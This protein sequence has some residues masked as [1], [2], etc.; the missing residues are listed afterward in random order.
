MTPH[1]RSLG[2]SHALAVVGAIVL[3]VACV[4]PWW[5]AGGGEGIPAA[6][7][8][9][10]E[11][12]G[13]LVFLVAIATLALVALPYAAGDR[14]VALDR[15]LSYAILS[16]VGWIGIGLR[17]FQLALQEP[18]VLLPD[19]APGLWLAVVGMI[20]ITRATYD[21]SRTPAYR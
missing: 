1:R 14:P 13:I 7:G 3:L 11:S 19:R 20:I 10:F 18:A 4:L 15:W 21:L 5:R 2:R 17:V 12:S 8:N 6:S 16:A 9:A